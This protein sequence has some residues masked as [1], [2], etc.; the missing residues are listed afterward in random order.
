MQAQQAC[1]LPGSIQEAQAATSAGPDTACND[2]SIHD[3]Q[4]PQQEHGEEEE[5]AEMP[6]A[7]S[8]KAG[9]LKK[10]C[11]RSGPDS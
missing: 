5:E 3:Q 1:I 8:M 4:Q 9:Q 10:Q 7:S 11:A 6:A 2:A